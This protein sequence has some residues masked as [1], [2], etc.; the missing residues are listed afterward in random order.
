MNSRD[1]NG[2][3]LSFLA[4][5]WTAEVP[6]CGQVSCMI[7]KK[8]RDKKCHPQFPHLSPLGPEQTTDRRSTRDNDDR[9]VGTGVRST[10]HCRQS[11]DMSNVFERHPFPP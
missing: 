11:V 9:G 7:E 3:R 1:K 2:V 10:Q 6:H 8:K 4:G 5:C